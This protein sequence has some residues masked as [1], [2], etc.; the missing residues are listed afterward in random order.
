MVKKVVGGYINVEEA[1]AQVE[2][3]YAEG[4][5]SSDVVVV[6]KSANKGAIESLT[7]VNVDP[8]ADKTGVAKGDPSLINYGDADNPLGMYRL[9]AETK[10]HYTKTIRNDGYVVLVEQRATR[11]QAGNDLERSPVKSKDDPTIPTI[12]EVSESYRGKPEDTDENPTVEGIPAATSD[13]EQ[14]VNE[15]NM[16]FSPG[17]PRDPSES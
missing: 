1:A 15:K 13:K 12:G 5:D 11:K 9:D 8:V 10:E 2:H 14:E 6:T 7:S 4:Y 16:P 3:L 17:T